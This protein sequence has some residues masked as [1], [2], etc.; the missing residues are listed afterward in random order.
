M[1]NDAR[2][3]DI[4]AKDSCSLAVTPYREGIEKV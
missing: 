1:L 4:K 3:I 2:S